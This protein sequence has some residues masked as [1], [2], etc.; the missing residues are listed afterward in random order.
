MSKTLSKDEN[1]LAKRKT[2]SAA[3]AK[4][5]APWEPARV[6]VGAT[7]RSF[8][9]LEFIAAS[10]RPLTASDISDALSLPKPSTYRLLESL[11][12]AGFV[13]RHGKQRR[14]STGPR[15]TDLAFNV[16]KSS[17]NYAPRRQILDALVKEVG[18]TCNIGALDH[19]EIVYL[20]RVEAEDWPLRLQFKI[21]SKVPLH[22]TA[23]G[24]L[25]LAFMP[26]DKSRHFLDKLDFD[27]YTPN[28]IL[29][30]KAL[31]AELQ[32][33]RKEGLSLDREEYIAGVVCI[34]APILDRNRNIQAAVA[35]QAPSARMTVA[36]ALENR[37][38]LARAAYQL[39]Q[40]FAL[41]TSSG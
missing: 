31:E 4:R 25:F 23:I 41:A 38:A 34:A 2:D 32:D 6:P 19:N 9:I 29:T 36:Q 37:D 40:S 3:S 20:D 39:S 17:L 7:D 12:R 14:I 24:K 11:E 28:T 18:E 10:G 15:L 33:I 8:A 27:R 21:G 30:R 16:L 5:K 13:S 26:E 1:S 35:I 22:C